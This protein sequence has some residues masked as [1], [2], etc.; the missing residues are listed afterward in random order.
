MHIHIAYVCDGEIVF[1]LRSVEMV[2]CLTMVVHRHVGDENGQVMLIGIGIEAMRNG[3]QQRESLRFRPK[4][5]LGCIRLELIL[6]AIRPPPTILFLYGVYSVTHNYATQN[7]TCLR[8]SIYLS[9][10]SV[11]MWI[12]VDGGGSSPCIVHNDP[13]PVSASFYPIIFGVH[14]HTRNE[15]K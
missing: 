6:S 4:V 13:F 3:W 1:I 11:R 9:A 14:T 5:M 2:Y 10:V 15:F 8:L 7:S 12:D